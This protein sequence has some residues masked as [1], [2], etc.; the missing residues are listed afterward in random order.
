MNTHTIKTQNQKQKQTS[1]RIKEQS[2]KA[3]WDKI[4]LKYYLIHFVLGIYF[5]E[6][7]LF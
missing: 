5:W 2:N 3:I 7:G 6:W 4:L 1:K